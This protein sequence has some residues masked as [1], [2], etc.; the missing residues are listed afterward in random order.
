[1]SQSVVLINPIY[2]PTQAELEAS[3]K[4]HKLWEAADQSKLLSEV[5]D[6]VRGIVTD[7]GSGASAE[8]MRQLPNV[9][10]M[11]SLIWHWHYAL[12]VTVK[13]RLGIILPGRGSGSRTGRCS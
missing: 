12:P 5:A 11:M 3:Y 7:G 2:G 1:M 10:V 6:E 13:F 4:V 9:E 8:L